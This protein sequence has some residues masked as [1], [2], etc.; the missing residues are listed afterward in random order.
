MSEDIKTTSTAAKEYGEL[1]RKYHSDLDVSIFID[2]TIWNHH[3][4][5]TLEVTLWCSFC[6]EHYKSFKQFNEKH[7]DV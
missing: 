2:R 6:G 1:A 4:R 3:N 5:T 7:G